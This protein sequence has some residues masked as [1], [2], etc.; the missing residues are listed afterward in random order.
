MSINE[1]GDCVFACAR[2]SK[3]FWP[4][5]TNNAVLGPTMDQNGSHRRA[6]E[7]KC[8][9]NCNGFEDNLIIT[10]KSCCCCSVCFS[11]YVATQNNLIDFL[12]SAQALLMFEARCLLD[13]RQTDVKGVKVIKTHKITHTRK[14]R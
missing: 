4:N 8:S 6:D 10:V 13:S 7:E 5:R 14:Q 3:I 9:C 11:C 12:F 1:F 2:R